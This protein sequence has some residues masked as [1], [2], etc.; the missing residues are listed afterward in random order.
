MSEQFVTVQLGSIF[1]NFRSRVNV[2]I[3]NI[4]TEGGA[5][6]RREEEASI[7]LRWFDSGATLASLEEEMDTQPE[8][9]VYRLIPT[10][11]SKRGAPYPLFGEYGTGRAGAASGRPAPAGYKYG[12]RTGMKARRYSRIAVGLAKP[13]IVTN[14]K[15]LIANFT[16]N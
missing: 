4:A 5:I 6:L 7:R 16:T 12:D 10:A 2:L 13:L 9:R 1:S 3:D 15:Q 14:A 8:R 11:T